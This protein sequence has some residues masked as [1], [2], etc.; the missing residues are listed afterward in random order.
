MSLPPTGFTSEI[1]VV[2]PFLRVNLIIKIES[3]GS[4]YKKG[5]VDEI[6]LFSL[7]Y[8]VKKITF[9]RGLKIEVPLAK[10]SAFIDIHH[11]TII[12]A[13]YPEIVD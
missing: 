10:L 1:F 7:L 3:R 12:K 6:L 4:L 5:F 2:N 9:W 13:A 11:L 8:K